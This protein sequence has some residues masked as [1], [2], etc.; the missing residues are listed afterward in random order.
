[1]EQEE[2][3]FLEEWLPLEKA[4][5]KILAVV[6]VLADQKLAFRGTIND[7]CK[8]IGIGTTTNNKNAV[9]SSL[10]YLEKNGFVKVIYDGSVITVSLAAAV[11]KS[12]NIK[13]IRRV[14]YNLIREA[15]S[16]AAWE[17]MMKVFLF[18][19]D[20]REEN[21]LT[22]REIAKNLNISERTVQR[23]ISIIKEIRFPTY[24]NLNQKLKI[25]KI[26]VMNEDG[27]YICLGQTFTWVLD[28]SEN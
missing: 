13:K 22:H 15:K 18:L 8:E 12:N 9:K 28:F 14:W 27:K 26:N 6:S 16:E 2:I 25:E 19:I 1:M 7:L 23:C 5:F 3:V 24:D 11:E 10:Q 4:Y 21:L 20:I 17:T